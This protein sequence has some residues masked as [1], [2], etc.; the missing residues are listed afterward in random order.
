[1]SDGLGVWLSMSREREGDG[2]YD[3]ETKLAA[4]PD[5]PERGMSR[6][7]GA[8]S[9]PKPA[10]I[11]ERLLEEENACLKARVACLGKVDALLASKSPTGR[12][13]R[14]SR[15]WRGSTIRSGAC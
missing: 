2:R 1:M 3:C 14:S 8:K 7:K 10:P 5:H 6:P 11:R 9:K 15:R 13:R 4:V 12:N